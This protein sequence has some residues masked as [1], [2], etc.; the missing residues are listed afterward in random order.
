MTKT[1][2]PLMTKTPEP[3]KLGTPRPVLMK[4]PAPLTARDP[5]SA[6]PSIPAPTKEPRR[7]PAAGHGARGEH[8]LR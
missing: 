6:L 8:E 5:S 1:P 4:T 2:A 3:L 7:V